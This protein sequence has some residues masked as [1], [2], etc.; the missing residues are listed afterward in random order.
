[1]HKL[2][3]KINNFALIAFVFGVNFEYWDPFGLQGVFSIAKM[4]AIIYIASWAPNLKTIDLRPLK[5]FLI[6][7]IIYLLIE[8]FA[9]ALNTVYAAGVS[10]TFNFKLIQLLLL[11]VLIVSHIINEPKAVKWILNA[12][13]ASVLFLS[14]LSMV[15]LGVALDLTASNGRLIMFGE[16]PNMIGMKAAFVANIL[17]YYIINAKDNAYRLFYLGLLIPI[18]VMLIAAASRGAFLSIFL[19]VTI[20]SLGQKSPSIC[21][22]FCFF[23]L[24]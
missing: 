17:F 19:G 11:L 7:L 18:S 1:L 20:I 24:F 10:D 5:Y 9:S 2:F 23:F 8:F 13:I 22:G 15:G 3:H 12:F 21:N 14:V 16:N 6:P 4:T